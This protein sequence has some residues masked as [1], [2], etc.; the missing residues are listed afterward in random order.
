MKAILIP[1][2]TKENFRPKTELNAKILTF[3]KLLK[4]DT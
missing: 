2:G 1:K 3:S 4:Y